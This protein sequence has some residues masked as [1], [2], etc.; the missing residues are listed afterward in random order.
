MLKKI[1]ESLKLPETRVIEDLDHFTTSE[2]HAQIIQKKP[3]L[4]RIY[5]DFYK[6]FANV[7]NE[8]PSG[9]FFEIGSGGGFLKQVYPRII[10]SDIL[11][12]SH[13]DICFDAQKLPLKKKS[14]DGFFL[15]NVFHHIKDPILFLSE[16]DRCLK[17]G[18]TI[19][20]IE[21]ANTPWARFI[22]QHFHH[23]PFDPQA[24]WILKEGGPLSG[25]NGALPWIIFERDKSGFL[26]KF[27]SF[28][29][30][31]IRYFM[32][33]RYLISGGLTLRQLLPTCCYGMVK[34][35]EWI[36]SPVNRLGAMFLV[37]KIYKKQ[38]TESN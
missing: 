29:I 4:R 14:A 9:L 1:I 3:F 25:A 27:P 2:L 18:G 21:P 13:V 20:M 30:K 23:E 6:Q 7:V 17:P 24:G 37:I 19:V 28:A 38:A 32:P 26:L 16:L 8:N 33:F 5:L 15:I 22:Y 34:F 12:V 11:K 35:F 10:T 36:L 31:R